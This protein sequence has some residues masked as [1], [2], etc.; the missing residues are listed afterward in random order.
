MFGYLG[1][2]FPTAHQILAE[3]YRQGGIIPPAPSVTAIKLAEV[4]SVHTGEHNEMC[5][6]MEVLAQAMPDIMRGL[7]AAFVALVIGL[8]AAWIAYNQFLVARA[9][10]NLDLFERRYAIFM[11][12]QAFASHVLVG[13]APEWNGAEWDAFRSDFHQ[14]EFLFGK[15]L[16]DYC[17]KMHTAGY[18][19]KHFYDLA[20]RNGG[21]M[22]QDH[23]EED[24]KLRVWFTEQAGAEVRER[25]GPYL[26]FERWK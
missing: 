10:L 17:D 16:A 2:L 4:R 1:Y 25:F 3:T 20:M 15:E 19:L 5:T 21:V 24:Y 9:K 23:I 12:V 18:K 6:C 14:T 26:N 11:N 13:Q 8:V 22:C 7:P